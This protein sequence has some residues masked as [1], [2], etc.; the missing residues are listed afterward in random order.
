DERIWHH[1]DS[2]KRCPKELTG[3]VDLSRDS[4]GNTRARLLDLV[5]GRSRKA[6]ASWLESRGEAL[7]RT[8][9]IAALDPFTGY[10]TAIDDKLEDAVA[11]LDAFHVVTLDTAAVDEVRRRVQQ[12]TLGHRGRKG[13][14]A[15]RNP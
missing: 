11:V 13:D 2:R 6:Y 8:V 5:L 15:L 12:D 7:R 4:T 9:K 14:P 1:V 10:K 3:M